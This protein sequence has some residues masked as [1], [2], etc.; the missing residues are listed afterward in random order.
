MAQPN[1]Q[2]TPKDAGP[3]LSS[4]GITGPMPTE[5]GGLR[6]IRESLLTK[7]GEAETATAEAKRAAAGRREVGEEKLYREERVATEPMR[8]ELLTKIGEKPY[9]PPTRDNFNTFVGMFSVLSALTFAVGG[10]GRGAGMGAL[11]ALNGAMEGYNKGEKDAFDR[12]MKEFDK[13]LA[14][15]KT[16]LEGTREALRVVADREGLRT[17]EGIAALKR[18]ELNDQGVTAALIREN[19]F[20]DAINH[21]DNLIRKVDGVE[22]Q[23]EAFKNSQLLKQIA[24]GR[25]EGRIN[26]TTQPEAVMRNARTTIGLAN[27]IEKA[28][29]NP[30]VRKEFDSSQLFRIILETP[31]EQ[32]ALR[33]VISQNIYQS[34][35]PATQKLF[36]QIATMRND[37][38]RQIS[39]QAVTG[40]EAARNFFATVSPSDNST[41]LINKIDVI[42]PR[43]VQELNEIVEG[44][45]IPKVIQDNLRAVID[46]NKVY[47]FD[48]Q[49]DAEA[50]E[51]SGLIKKGDRVVVGGRPG[52]V[53]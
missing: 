2:P 19:R 3:L 41:T 5:S 34:L 7:K 28:L 16:T 33:K 25:D 18:A 50:A 17:R 44:Y 39:G 15:Y 26:L 9:P 13:Q 37:Y 36:T 46:A 42:R 27:V 22:R 20:K 24:A 52:R 21:I 35:T 1:Q 4:L 32:D 49:Q 14:N 51:S 10:K 12:G 38:F 45:K 47:E 30:Q 8:Q 29:E 11:A 43:L 53:Q 23:N 40:S 31:K 48:T 6:D